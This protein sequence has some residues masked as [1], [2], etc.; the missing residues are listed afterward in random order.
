MVVIVFIDEEVQNRISIQHDDS[1][2][3]Y[4]REIALDALDDLKK[5]LKQLN[6]FPKRSLEYRLLIL[7]IQR[8]VLDVKSLIENIIGDDID[9]PEEINYPEITGEENDINR[10][11]DLLL[12]M[13]SLT[14]EK[15]LGDDI[16]EGMALFLAFYEKIN[17]NVCTA[18]ISDAS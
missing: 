14:E 3:E 13:I 2:L 8:R 1:V 17:V 6:I 16:I 9:P 15:L 18:C 7:D 5:S 10:E 12:E 11:I 4:F